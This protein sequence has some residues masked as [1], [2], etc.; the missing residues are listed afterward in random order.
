MSTNAEDEKKNTWFWDTIIKALKDAREFLPDAMKDTKSIV[1]SIFSMFMQGAEFF[2]KIFADFSLY[3]ADS[4]YDL[5]SKELQTEGA[6]MFLDKIQELKLNNEQR[7]VLLHQWRQD[8]KDRSLAWVALAQYGLD[9]GE[10][11]MSC[12]QNIIN[13]CLDTIKKKVKI[14]SRNEDSAITTE[15]QNEALLIKNAELE[16]IAQNI[17]LEKE[18][19]NAKQIENLQQQEHYKNLLK[20]GEAHLKNILKIGTDFI[21]LHYNMYKD[22]AS[23]IPV[24]AVVSDDVLH[25]KFDDLN[26]RLKGVLPL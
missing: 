19:V 6:Q 2:K 10:K 18:L 11:G 15:F 25:R 21:T 22:N 13:E 7:V 8:P 14:T 26:R 16:Q 4:R 20:N 12:A 23:G 17:K 5:S 3:P 1:G 9:M 24:P